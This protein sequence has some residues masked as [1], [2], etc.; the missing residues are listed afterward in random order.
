MCLENSTR[1]AEAEQPSDRGLQYATCS[2]GWMIYRFRKSRIL[3]SWIKGDLGV[4]LPVV[5]GRVW[6]MVDRK[7]SRGFGFWPIVV[8][9]K[10]GKLAESHASVVLAEQ[11]CDKED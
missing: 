11:E 10:T 5:A 2:V 9:T 4:E 1:L 7:V 8:F 3:Q 6:L